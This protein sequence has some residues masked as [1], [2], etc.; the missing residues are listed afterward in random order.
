LHL[1]RRR[2]QTRLRGS[3]EALQN[4]PD[5]FQSLSAFEKI[6]KEPVQA[7]ILVTDPIQMQKSTTGKFHCRRF[8]R[9]LFVPPPHRRLEGIHP[10][11]FLARVALRASFFVGLSAR[12]R[13][14]LGA[15]LNTARSRR[16]Q[17][18]ECLASCVSLAYREF[19]LLGRDCR[20]T[21][22]RKR[23][24]RAFIASN[25]ARIRLCVKTVVR[26]LAQSPGT[27]EGIRKAEKSKT[28]DASDT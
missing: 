10:G 20:T 12:E 27:N 24:A 26:G 13:R 23:D 4:D 16:V 28:Q 17:E 18:F 2:S 15:S 22:T 14:A 8:L 21:K 6:K 9:S 7:L 19:G 5:P 1:P 11:R 25:A 3:W